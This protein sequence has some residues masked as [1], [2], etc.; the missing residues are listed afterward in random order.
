MTV[1]TQHVKI[2]SDTGFASSSLERR[3]LENGMA[4]KL[5]SLAPAMFVRSAWDATTSRQST[6]VAQ[7]LGGVRD[8][9]VAKAADTPGLFVESGVGEV[10]HQSG[11]QAT[12]S[13]R[14]FLLGRVPTAS[15][16]RPESGLTLALWFQSLAKGVLEPD[17]A[18]PWQ[19]FRRDLPTRQVL[20]AT[21]LEELTQRA[22]LMARDPQGFFAEV[23]RQSSAFVSLKE[24]MME[25][26]NHVGVFT[27]QDTQ[28]AIYIVGRAPDD[29]VCGLVSKSP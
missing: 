6:S 14:D 3:L 1:V 17:T 4:T 21:T 19:A 23:S 27:T 18:A 29:S 28:P 24:A 9:Y 12:V 2:L 16:A 26:I 15:T 10:V 5:V 20:N 8:R 11:V 13:A 25:H 22:K 7:T